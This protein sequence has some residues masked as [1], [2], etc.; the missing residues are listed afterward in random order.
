VPA[1]PVTPDR[2]GSEGPLSTAY[3]VVGIGASAGGLEAFGELLHALPPHPGLAIVLV[4]HLASQVESALPALLGSRTSLP[5][6]QATEGVPIEKNRVFVIPPNTQMRM[7]DGTLHLVPRPHDRTQY[8]PI[9]IFFHSL[10]EAARENA[11]AVILSGTASDGTI[12]IREVKAAGGIV[13]VQQP[14]TAKYDGMPRAAIG[15][16]AVDAVLGLPEIAA[17]LVRIAAHPFRERSEARAHEPAGA[18]GPEPDEEAFQRALRVLRT[19]T[20]VDFTRYKRPTVERRLHRRM[21]LQ[22]FTRIEQYVRFLQESPAETHA[23][24]QDILIHVTRFFRE[25]E[26]FAALTKEVFPWIVAGRQAESP[27]RVWTPG[28]STGEESYSVA[29]ALLEHLGDQG[30]NVPLQLFATDVSEPAIEHARAGVYPA[31]IAADVSPA[32]LRRFFTK[33]EGGYRVS[34]T[35]RDLCVFARQDLTR[36]PPFSK[37]DLIVCRNVMI[38][39]GPELQ[40]KLIGVFHYALKPTGY[41]VLGNAETI[42]PYSGLFS[43]TDKKHRVYQKKLAST[44]AMTFPVERGAP[45]TVADRKP[46]P[47]RVD[48]TRAV[49]SEASRLVQERFAPPGVVIDRD[50]Q[51]VQFRGQTGVFFEPAAG[52]PSHNVLK[53]AREGLLH[54][55]RSAIQDAQRGWKAVRREGLR[56]RTDAGWREVDLEVLPLGSQDRRY[57][58]VL[59]EA[60]GSRRAPGAARREVRPGKAGKPA[61]HGPAPRLGE[62]TRLEDELASTRE[63]LQS[64]IQ[65][66]EAANEE[67]QSANEEILSANEEL[68]STNEELDTAKEELQSTNEELNTVNEELHARNEELM[69]VNSD[70]VNLLGSVQIAI[71]I[72][73]SD[74][75]IRRFTPMAERVLNLIASDVGRPISHIKPNIDCDDL[76]DLVHRVIEQV[77][78]IEREVRDRQ[79]NRYVLRV[80]PY[81]NVENRIEGAVLALFEVHPASAE[82]DARHVARAWADAILEAAHDPILVLDDEGRVRGM[83]A[84]FTAC[85][86]VAPDAAAGRPV[87]ELPAPSWPGRAVARLARDLAKTTDTLSAVGVGGDGH[88]RLVVNGRRIPAHAGGGVQVVL[89]FQEPPAG[90]NS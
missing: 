18:G 88:A 51:V 38:Y 41:L 49:L 67:L 29:I 21:L 42:G 5:V 6:V 80:R 11:I 71:V 57:L 17:E 87:A 84:A 64:I 68:Q 33:I 13:L 60:D 19:A 40:K 10:A 79:G 63:H 75:R 12:G 70:L 78:P 45:T 82:A 25:P 20:G 35:V 4:P 59:F 83:N 43:V 8:T 47:L 58:L 22:K 7:V 32:R 90:G 30:P 66:L 2:G 15:T 53:L 74:L 31:A 69:R 89:A 36:D 73:A 24:Y 72:V 86:G 16:G 55:L 26:S 9:D 39:M 77:A 52:D 23:L 50:L 56:V 3:P 54:G 61:R 37:L 65:E 81:K 14:E 76:E 27:I 28:C 34:K 48:D 62:V 85:F 46:E 44:P 1:K